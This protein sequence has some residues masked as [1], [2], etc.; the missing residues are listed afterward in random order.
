VLEAAVATGSWARASRLPAPLAGTVEQAAPNGPDAVI[1]DA[2]VGEAA[3]VWLPAVSAVLLQA[4]P[5][6]AIP[7][8]P[9]TAARRGVRR[10]SIA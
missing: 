6:S 2:V 3:G 1:G 10:R 5:M 4:A 8:T 7:S 9:T